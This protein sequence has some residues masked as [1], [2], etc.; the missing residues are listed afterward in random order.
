ME[1]VTDLTEKYYQLYRN[2]ISR[3]EPASSP[4]LNKNREEA[5]ERFRQLGIPSGKN[6]A[7]KFITFQSVKHWII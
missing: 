3:I 7:Y 5:I 6:E 2:N 1:P 4:L